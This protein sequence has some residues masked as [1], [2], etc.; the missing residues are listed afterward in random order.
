VIHRNTV[1]ALTM[2]N[3]NILHIFH[4]GILKTHVTGSNIRFL[5]QREEIDTRGK[6]LS[7]FLGQTWRGMTGGRQTGLASIKG[8]SWWEQE[9][10]IPSSENSQNSFI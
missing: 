7:V 9:S 4:P 10:Y 3:I 8:Q 6:R 2:Q 5:P 1:F